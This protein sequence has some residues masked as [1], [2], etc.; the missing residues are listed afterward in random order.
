MTG[1][2]S[3]DLETLAV[4]YTKE[5]MPRLFQEVLGDHEVRDV[6]A[7]VDQAEM[8]FHGLEKSYVA[9]M[10]CWTNVDDFKSK[11]YLSYNC[12]HFY[13]P[14]KRRADSRQAVSTAMSGL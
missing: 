1:K 10:R 14:S 8:L 3:K 13:M 7:D 11:V 12:F 2:Y 5:F 4:A 9:D 6:L